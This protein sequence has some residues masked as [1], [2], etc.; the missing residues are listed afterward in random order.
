M[1][2]RP[3]WWIQ[4]GFGVYWWVVGF[5]GGLGVFWLIVKILE[6]GFTGSLAVIFRGFTGVLGVLRSFSGGLGACF[7]TNR[8]ILHHAGKLAEAYDGF[9]CFQKPWN[10]KLGQLVVPN[11]LSNFGPTY[12]CKIRRTR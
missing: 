2:W 10:G 3:M 12:F 6:S 4:V 8:A 1:A 9:F 5:I 11:M 7:F